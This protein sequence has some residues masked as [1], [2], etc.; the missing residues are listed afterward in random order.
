L[1]SGDIEGAYEI[2][3]KLINNTDEEGKKIW[4]PVTERNYSAFHN[5]SL[6]NFIRANGNFSNAI[7]ESLYFLECDLVQKF[8]S[9]VADETHKT[10]KKELQLLFLNQLHSD[11]EANNKSLLPK[12][13][14]TLNKQEFI[15]K[16]DFMKGFVQKYIEQIEHKIETAKNKRKADKAN[17]AEAGQELYTSTS[18]DLAQFKSIVG[19]SDLKYTSI[20]DKIASEI[21]QCSID[22]FNYMQEIDSETDYPEIAMKL[23]KQAETIAVG[24]LTKDRIK[25]NIETLE[26]MKEKELVQAIELLKSIK[27]AYETNKA[28]IID[29]VRAMPLRY[30]QRINWSK[31]NQMIEKSIDWDKVVEL[32]LQVIPPQ[33]IEKIKQAS[34]ASNISEY[35]SLVEFVLSEIS[36]PY[37]SRIAYINYWET[38]K[39][40][41]R[42]QSDF[43]FAPNAW[44]IL[45]FVGFIIGAMA[46]KEG[47]NVVGALIGV[48]I[49]LTVNNI[50]KI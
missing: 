17:A 44:W 43:E 37:K 35:K 2:W 10:N 38:P 7:V 46:G 5:Y 23:A 36:N 34:N 33:N 32:I 19:A 40:T 25:D 6:L 50:K 47:V 3:D 31:V 30:N 28:T 9:S 12:F 13:L 48:V 20:A 45:G 16:Q 1:K 41:T 49:G 8:V 4:K 27:E 21:L 26:R 22:Y 42:S 24:K 18:N 11:I 14:E 15:A 29:K 39:R